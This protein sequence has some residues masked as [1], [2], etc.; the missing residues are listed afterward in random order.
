MSWGPTQPRRNFLTGIFAKNFAAG[1]LEA[2]GLFH[3]LVTSG[4]GTL[5]GEPWSVIAGH[6]TFGAGEEDLA[7]LERLG[8]LASRAG[9][10]LLA[11]ASP[12]LYGCET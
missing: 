11:A 4:A 3:R 2:S 1:D 9:G 12:A 10:P 7:V 5:G 6:Y 8:A